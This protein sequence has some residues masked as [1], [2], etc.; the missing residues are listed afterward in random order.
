MARQ[1]V[2]SPQKSAHVAGKAVDILQTDTGRRRRRRREGE[3]AGT[4]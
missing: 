2:N 4:G 3:A 1:Y